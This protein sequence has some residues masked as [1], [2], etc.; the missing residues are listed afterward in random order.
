MLED[1][2]LSDNYILVK[3]ALGAAT[4]LPLGGFMPKFS[5]RSL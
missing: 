5:K 4:K 2:G 1:V 3:K